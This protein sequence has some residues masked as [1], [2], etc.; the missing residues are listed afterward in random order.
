MT[1]ERRAELLSINRELAALL[2]LDRARE[3]A[4]ASGSPR[5]CR[6]YRQAILAAQD[7]TRAVRMAM[8]D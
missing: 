6:A 1:L 7:A 3:R 5:D 8:A 4:D 2:A